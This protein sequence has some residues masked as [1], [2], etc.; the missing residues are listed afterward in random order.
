MM[1]DT[2]IAINTCN[3]NNTIIAIIGRFDSDD[4]AMIVGI[5]PPHYHFYSL[6]IKGLA[7]KL[8]MI[9]M[10]VGVCTHATRKEGRREGENGLYTTGN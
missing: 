3:T 5:V 9:A 8:A 7:L 2:N 4:S 6:I 10:I 1:I